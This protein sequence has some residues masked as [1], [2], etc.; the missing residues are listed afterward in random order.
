VLSR[1]GVLHADLV[2]AERIDLGQVGGDRPGAQSGLVFLSYCGT[3]GRGTDREPWG[4]LDC[5]IVSL[6]AR[7]FGVLVPTLRFLG[8]DMV[9]VIA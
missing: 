6:I 4:T 2:L 8:G 7:L 5:L 1:P 3:L 9:E